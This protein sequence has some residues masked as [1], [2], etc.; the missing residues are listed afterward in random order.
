MKVPGLV[1]LYQKKNWKDPPLFMG[2]L[3]NLTINHHFS[4]Q[5]VS[6]PGANPSSQVEGPL[7]FLVRQGRGDPDFLAIKH[8]VQIKSSLDHQCLEEPFFVAT[9]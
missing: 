4:S 1:N 5:T 2:K 3:T 8:Y 9:F 6:L 7:H